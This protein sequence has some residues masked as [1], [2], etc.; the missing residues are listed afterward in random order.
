[1]ALI[2]TSL[3]NGTGNRVSV[4]WWQ[5]GCGVGLPATCPEKRHRPLRRTGQFRLDE[6][7]AT[8]DV[9]W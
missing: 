6:V 9:N 2:G 4:N 7:N 3:T 8:G 1:M 5:F